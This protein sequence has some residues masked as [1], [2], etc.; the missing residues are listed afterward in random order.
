MKYSKDE[1]VEIYT[2]SEVAFS[3]GICVYED[4]DK[5]IYMNVDPRGMIDGY[6]LVM[7]RYISSIEKETEYLSMINSYM[8]YAEKHPY[9]DWFKLKEI[10]FHGD[11]IR[12]ILCTAAEENNILAIKTGTNDF[13]YEGYVSCDGEFIHMKCIDVSTAKLM[14]CVE[15]PISKINWIGFGEAEQMLL[16]YAHKEISCK[17]LYRLIISDT[18]LSYEGYSENFHIGIFETKAI[19]E[20]TAAYYLENIAGFKDYSCRYQVEEKCVYGSLTNSEL[21]EVWIVWGYSYNDKGDETDI[22]E[23]QLFC[24]KEQ[25]ENELERLKSDYKRDEWGVDKY[26]IG[27]KNWTEGFIRV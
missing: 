5:C 3:V 8:S 11:V 13:I 16:D 10:D 12:Q 6:Y 14:E 26:I 24:T 27:A 15:L 18:E 22:I 19:A 20:A 4:D 25:A 2:S 9:S 7:K 1:L 17:V 21:K 23:S